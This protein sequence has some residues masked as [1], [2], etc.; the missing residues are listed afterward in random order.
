MNVESGKVVEENS[1]SNAT[2]TFCLVVCLG[3]LSSF[4]S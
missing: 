2:A 1:L 4:V 3:D